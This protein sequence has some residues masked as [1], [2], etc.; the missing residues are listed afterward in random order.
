[1][2]TQRP[3][4][5]WSFRIARIAG[6]DIRVHLTMVLFLA[7]VVLEHLQQGKAALLVEGL[8]L[9]AC[10]FAFV[11]LHELA[12]VLVARR[13]GITTRDITLLPIGGVASMERLPE[14]PSQEIAVALAGPLVNVAL[15]ALLFAGLVLGQLVIDARVLQ[16]VGGPFLGKLLVINLSIAVFNLVP[17]FPM[18][19]GRVLRALLARGRSRERA[20]EIAARI[21]QV[22]AFAFAG[23]G[24]LLSP[25]LLLIALFVWMGAEQERVVAKLQAKLAPLKVRDA[26]VSSFTSLDADT[27]ICEAMDL[28]TRGFQHDFPVRSGGRVVGLLSREELVATAELEGD[29]APVAHALHGPLTTLESSTPLSAALEVMRA[30]DSRTAIV[31]D[32]GQLAGLLTAENVA[33]RLMRPAS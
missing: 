31:V 27:P 6:V 32:H 10:T 33:E 8:A 7:W 15:A 23:A 11:T 19:G 20:T 30:N 14:R 9:G 17:A 21:G 16:L 13:Y 5:R 4:F 25:G 3:S 29:N 24:V 12:H 28:S 18:D 22:L 2:S 26:M 1:M